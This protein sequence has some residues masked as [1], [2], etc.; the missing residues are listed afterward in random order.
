[1]EEGIEMDEDFF[2][3]TQ[4]E[5]EKTTVLYMDA[6]HLGR[7]EK[8]KKLADKLYLIGETQYMASLG[9]VDIADALLDIEESSEGR[10]ELR[11]IRAHF[12]S[13]AQQYQDWMNLFFE[14][15][16]GEGL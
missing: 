2:D 5:Y 9:F 12:V 3:I 14:V 7:K 13:I 8:A 10:E 1:M 15:Q 16:I 4:A 11:E 6:V